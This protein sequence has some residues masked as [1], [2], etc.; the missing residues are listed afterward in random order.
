MYL[1]TTQNTHPRYLDLADDRRR[2]FS[3]VLVGDQIVD[4]VRVAL[5]IP[6]A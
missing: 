3:I 6:A 2:T 1:W 5:A 4:L